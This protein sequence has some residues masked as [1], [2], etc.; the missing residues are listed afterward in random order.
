MTTLFFVLALISVV[1]LLIN[2]YLI[3]RIDIQLEQQDEGY[4]P[5]RSEKLHYYRMHRTQT[6]L[7][8]LVI[9]FEAIGFVFM[10]I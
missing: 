1:L 3:F 9:L 8:S 4:K 2:R 7:L 6:W 10:S 5:L